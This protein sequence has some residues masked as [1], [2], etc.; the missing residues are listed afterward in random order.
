MTVADYALAALGL[1]ACLAWCGGSFLVASV[2]AFTPVP[3]E[4]TAATARKGCASLICAVGAAAYLFGVLW[5]GQWG[6]L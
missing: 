4:E 2:G 6:W 1:L 5:N 3:N